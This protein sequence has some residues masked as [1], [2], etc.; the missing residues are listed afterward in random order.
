MTEY[1]SACR[2]A[3]KN[4]VRF[5]RFWC[6]VLLALPMMNLQMR[7]SDYMRP[8]ARRAMVWLR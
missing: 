7:V 1:G 4:S 5:S 2:G 3:M 8:P 6:Y